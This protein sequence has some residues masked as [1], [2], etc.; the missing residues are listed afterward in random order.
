M[1]HLSSSADLLFVRQFESCE[2][3]PP[4]SHRDH[5]RLAYVYLTECDVATSHP[6]LKQ[7][8]L[9]YLQHHGVDLSK[10]HETLTRAWLMVVRHFMAISPRS[11]SAAS[12]LEHKPRLLDSRIMLK[13][14]TPE[15]LF[16][17]EARSRFLEPDLLPIPQYRT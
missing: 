9:R 13:H 2:L 7:A 8:L 6:V 16:S 4:F 3:L 10:Y 17:D 14:Y 12:F 15:R 5:V 1:E 11:G